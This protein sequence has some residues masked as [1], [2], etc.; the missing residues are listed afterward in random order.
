MGRGVVHADAEFAGAIVEVERA[1]LEDGEAFPRVEIR[2]INEIVEQR[3]QITVIADETIH[4]GDG[5]ELRLEG[6]VLGEQVGEDSAALAGEE[7]LG[8]VESEFFHDGPGLAAEPGFVGGELGV[9]CGPIR[10]GE[11]GFRGAVHRRDCGGMQRGERA[12]PGG[13]DRV[14]QRQRPVGFD[15]REGKTGDLLG[16]DLQVLGRDGEVL[17][18]LAIE[19]GDG[20]AVEGRQPAAG[21]IVVHLGADGADGGA[22]GGGAGAEHG[23]LLGRAFFQ[24]RNIGGELGEKRLGHFRGDADGARAIGDAAEAGEDIRDQGLRLHIGGGIGRNHA[25]AIERAGGKELGGVR[26]GGDKDGTGAGLAEA[27]E[28]LLGAGEDGLAV[29]GGV[30]DRLE[31][32]RVGA[33]QQYGRVFQAGGGPVHGG[34]QLRDAD[35]AVAI[36]IDQ[37]QGFLIEFEA[38]DR[39]GQRDPQ[40]LVQPVQCEEVLGRGEGDLVE[41]AGAEKILGVGGG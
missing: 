16:G 15:A 4:G 1:G 8:A 29:E 7:G 27:G 33:L 9:E 18:F 26:G 34:N 13:I 32:E 10:L 17:G 3:P 23:D 38:L 36:G 30:I 5:V 19:R 12:G 22:G 40:L 20:A 37:R 35:A 11:R 28:D 24:P 14:Q 41:A 6:L 31:R 2:E 21:E 25:V 39:A